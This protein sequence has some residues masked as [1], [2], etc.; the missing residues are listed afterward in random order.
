MQCLCFI[1]FCAYEALFPFQI[2]ALW[3]IFADKIED[4]QEAIV[5]LQLQWALHF[6]QK[7]IFENDIHSNMLAFPKNSSIIEE[8]RPSS[9]QNP[10]TKCFYGKWLR[11][12][13]GNCIVVAS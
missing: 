2:D 10:S 12:P 7:C 13:H 8:W 5:H 9:V 4:K 6:P 3:V 11:S 1:S